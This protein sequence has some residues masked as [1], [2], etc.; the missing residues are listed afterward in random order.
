[1]K[2]ELN[3]IDRLVM[4]EVPLGTYIKIYNPFS[5]HWCIFELISY[6]RDTDEEFMLGQ[7]DGVI[8]VKGRWLET[9]M[10][11]WKSECYERKIDILG[12]G[13]G[14]THTADYAFILT[15]EEVMIEVL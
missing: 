15:K 1:L 4:E 3:I 12:I 13:Y 9:D 2:Q 6:Y 11:N 7:G 10:S 8:Y 14:D 5:E